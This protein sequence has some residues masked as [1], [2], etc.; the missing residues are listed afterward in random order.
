MYP[1]AVTRSER[2]GRGDHGLGVGD[3]ARERLLAEHVLACGKQPSDHLAVQ[4][5]GHHD[6]D[7]VDIGGVGDRAP[8]VL[9]ALVAVAQRVVVGDGRVGVGDGDQPDVGSFGAEQRRRGA[10]SGGMRPAGHAAADDGD[11]DR[12]EVC[13]RASP[14]VS[15]SVSVPVY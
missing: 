15:E 11:T 5:V 4:V 1:T 13:H 9:G 14:V 6:A 3:R 10:V 2:V 8:V 12:V 7:R